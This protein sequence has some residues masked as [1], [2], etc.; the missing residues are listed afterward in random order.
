MF[1]ITANM[2][3]GGGGGGVGWTDKERGGEERITEEVG[4][5]GITWLKLIL[6][7]ATVSLGHYCVCVR[8]CAEMREK[9][10]VRVRDCLKQLQFD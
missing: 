5:R 9:Q 3:R 4:P 7:S 6:L 2:A 1:V 8:L 10:S